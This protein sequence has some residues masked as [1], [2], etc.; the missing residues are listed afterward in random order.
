MKKVLAILLISL[1]PLPFV[2]LGDDGVIT[3]NEQKVIA[4]A[5]ERNLEVKT[6]RIDKEIS[7]TGIQA[8]KSVFD[9]NL[10][11]RS[12]H[13]IDKN[14]QPIP[15][16][17]TDNRVTQFN[18]EVEK[19]LPIGT[20]T[21]MHWRNRRESTNSPFAVI[22]PFWES[23]LGLSLEQPFLKNFAGRA[24]RWNVSAARQRF[25]TSS[26]LTQRRI[27]E[28]IYQT[29]LVYW[30]WQFD[31]ENL[32]LT[33]RSL[34]EAR[35]FEETARLQNQ[36]ALNETTDIV[37]AQAN[38][39]RIE[40]QATDVV[41]E[42]EVS[43]LRLK[44]VLNL[45]PQ[46]KL[47]SGQRIPPMEKIPS[48]EEAL[49][50]A[51]AHRQDRLAA[52]SF[53]ESKQIELR[54]SKNLKWPALDLLASINLN[55]VDSGYGQGLLETVRADHPEFLIGTQ[56]K[57]PLENRL[58]KSEV[59]KAELE[60]VKAL[61]AF[62][63]LENQIDR[64]VREALQNLK[65]RAQEVANNRRAEA[66]ELKKWHLERDKYSTGRS[67]SDIVIRYQDD[68]LRAQRITLASLYF[69]RK[70]WLDLRAAMNDLLPKGGE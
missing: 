45:G 12:D 40:N 68:Y 28:T 24:D 43:L 52:I 47:R 53:L 26:A 29:V 50:W 48:T 13:L 61:Y 19:T 4:I 56:F 5:L 10:R 8:A 66:L 20:R 59:Q 3:L 15:I 42:R 38:R 21:Q 41:R 37:A 69:Y 27:L 31:L 60:K 18:V 63:Q 58:A 67:S 1:T 64:E 70:A 49:S 55:G 30:K 2:A 51:F 33:R 17:G 14:D 54:I 6:A 32:E 11:F 23:S 35:R 9:T 36:Y 16:F 44:E 7:R 57:M 46:V 34:H 25:E 62:K 65:S 39:V 22:N